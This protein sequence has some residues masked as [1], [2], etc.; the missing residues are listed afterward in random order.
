MTYGAIRRGKGKAQVSIEL[1]IASLNVKRWGMERYPRELCCGIAVRNTRL[2]LYLD[3]YASRYTSV[4]APRALY[5][6][7][8]LDEIIDTV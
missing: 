5:T 4:M 3:E 8:K 1:F 2:F 7:V 6:D